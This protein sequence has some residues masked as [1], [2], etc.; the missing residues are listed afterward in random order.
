MSDISKMSQASCPKCKSFLIFA[1]QRLPFIFPFIRLSE[2]PALAHS[3]N[4]SLKIFLA[5]DLLA[6]EFG[7]NGAVCDAVAKKPWLASL[8]AFCSLASAFPMEAFAFQPLGFVQRRVCFPRIL[9][10]SAPQRLRRNEMGSHCP[11]F[12][13]HL[14]SWF[15]KSGTSCPQPI[16]YL[17]SGI[18]CAAAF[19]GSKCITHLSRLVARRCCNLARDRRTI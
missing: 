5:R 1:L 19:H 16:M 4:K 11:L 14:P 6:E 2:K 7:V 15:L 9:L 12:S 17:L 13:N 8:T 18:Y 3:I 10:S